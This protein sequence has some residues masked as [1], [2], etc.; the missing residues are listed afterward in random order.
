MHEPTLSVILI[1]RNE[2]A[3]VAGCLAS[4]AFADEWIVVDWNSTDA[5]CEIARDLGAN[6]VSTSDW[7]G[8]GMQKNQALALARGRWVLSLDADERVTP[9][10]AAQIRRTC[11]LD[12]TGHESGSLAPAG[13]A[14]SRAMRFRDCRTSAANG[15]VTAIG[16]PI[17]C[18]ACFAA[19]PVV[20]PTTSCT[21]A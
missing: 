6:V 8:F 14:S 5:T 2:A 21:S 3:N 1:T 15:C 7:P 9:A 4:V 11:E 10:L 12:P 13:D 16:T 19:T 18:C 17:G 20:F